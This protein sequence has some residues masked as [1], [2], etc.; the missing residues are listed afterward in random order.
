[1]NM[2]QKLNLIWRIIR[3]KKS[4]LLSHADR[5]L[6]ALG[7]DEMG[8]AMA[9]DIRELVAVFCTQ[10]H[11]GFSASYA[12]SVLEKVM[13]FQPIAPLTGEDSEWSEFT[14]G[15]FQN[16]RCGH[17]FKGDPDR[18][19]G[20]AYDIDAV[21]FREPNGSQFTGRGS[22]QPVTFPYT[23]TTQ[24]IDVDDSGNP[25]NGWNREGIYRGM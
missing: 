22:W 1:M 20:K 12:V 23:P 15:Q 24:I 18:F 21:V 13:R 4:A 14:E 5:E 19:N 2:R 7:S 8:K 11:S 3:V 25:L 10:G 6:V 16:K 17:V 9:A